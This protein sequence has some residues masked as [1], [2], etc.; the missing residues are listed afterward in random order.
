MAGQVRLPVAKVA[1]AVVC[2]QAALRRDGDGWFALVEESAGKYLRRRV[3]VGLRTGGQVEV[4]DGLFPGDQVVRTGLQELASLFANAPRDKAEVAPGPPV[5]TLVSRPEG[6]SVLSALAE[7]E[8]PTDQKS[9]IAPPFSGRLANLL[10]ERG[11]FVRAGTLMAEVDS[12]ELTSLV[13]DTLRAQAELVAA[14]TQ[15]ERIADAE[16]QAAL[17]GQEL[18]QMKSRMAQAKNALAA[19]RERLRLASFS[20]EELA[21]LE[22]LEVSAMQ[23]DKPI[24]PR[25]RLR[26]PAD[27]WLADF[28]LSVGQNVGPQERLFELHDRSNLWVRADLFQE[29]LGRVR[30]GDGAR[31]F[32]TADPSLQVEG[33]VA[34]VTPIVEAA[35]RTGSVWIEIANPGA[36]CAKE[37]W[38]G[39]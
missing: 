26:A 37:C 20:P 7:I 2:P 34:R 22:Q 12:L 11:Q 13:L 39:P 27:G 6:T 32:F 23:G 21:A 18:W 1:E 35:G 9:F 3:E 14:Q 17:P 28:E 31:V 4:L 5:E 38:P 25:L 16:V 24:V 29:D 33:Q 19:N 10:V 8:T 15:V 36:D 30:K